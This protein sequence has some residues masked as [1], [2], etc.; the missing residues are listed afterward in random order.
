MK[1]TS[2]FSPGTWRKKRLQ[3]VL[4]DSPSSD[5]EKSCPQAGSVCEFPA[6]LSASYSASHTRSVVNV[7]SPKV[8]ED[9]PS[10][11]R[12]CPPSRPP[13]KPVLYSPN[14]T[15]P[16]GYR[17][18]EEAP[19]RPSRPPS[20]NLDTPATERTPPKTSEGKRPHARLT[21]STT[22][23]PPQTHASC[24]RTKVSLPELDGVWKGFLEEVEEDQH[25]LTASTGL[26]GPLPPGRR[27]RSVATV[28]SP[29]RV[30]R[31]QD[32]PPSPSYDKRLFEIKPPPMEDMHE[33]ESDSDDDD[34]A[35]A[36]SPST[37][38]FSA[39]LALFPPPPPLTIRRRPIPK[40]LEI[41]PPPVSTLPP[42]PSTSSLDSTPIAT[43]TTPTQSSIV[44]P[45]RCPKTKG[46]FSPEYVSPTPSPTR[47]PNR[48]SASDS[49]VQRLHTTRSFYHPPRN[50]PQLTASHRT[51]SS[52]SVSSCS[53]TDN[54]FGE[55]VWKFPNTSTLRY[56]V[57]SALS[58]VSS[59]T[60]YILPQE[61]SGRRAPSPTYTPVQ[62][63]IAV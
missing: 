25:S 14:N 39:S 12:S 1:G 31:F 34:D 28:R 40:P 35:E 2:I 24:L 41:R 52:E 38:G 26:R 13:S 4:S 58:L 16:G 7:G 3:R 32:L 56:L 36:E 61:T 47:P 33:S 55:R 63:G 8:Y 20:L 10:H 53:S 22:S 54:E 17:H 45:R 60:D 19:R 44:S 9:V 62:W 27:P 37:P 51:T 48:T 57:S 46:H 23:P 42:S 21:R 50:R 5:Q 11:P 15:S 6:T 18:S 49:V 43:P 30:K 29:P 59:L